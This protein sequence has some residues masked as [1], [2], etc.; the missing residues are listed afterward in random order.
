MAP[1]LSL[2]HRFIL[3]MVRK[4]EVLKVVILFFQPLRQLVVATVLR[5]LSP[6]RQRLT[7]AAVVVLVV[8]AVGFIR[9]VAVLAPR[10]KV[11]MAVL[12]TLEANPITGAV[13]AARVLGAV[14]THT[15]LLEEVE[16]HRA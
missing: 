14:V 1:L 9:A 2:T 8:A 13:A 4:A 7:L 6:M 3:V 11:I 16:P 12:D 15:L 5:L 10:G